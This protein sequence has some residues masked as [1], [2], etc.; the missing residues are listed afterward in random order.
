MAVLAA[1]VISLDKRKDSGFEVVA[2]GTV[3]VGSSWE[4]YIAVR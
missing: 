2:A 4:P 3:L 1:V